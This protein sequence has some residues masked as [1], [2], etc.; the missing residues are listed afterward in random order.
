[1][2]GLHMGHTSVRSNEG[3][4]P[5]S[6]ANR[7]IAEMLK[8]AG[9]VTGGFGKWGLGDADT[10]GVPWR[11]GF[12]RFFGYLHQV[13]AHFYYP[14]ELWDTGTRL[15]LPENAG[16]KKGGYAHDE[17]V[18]RALSFIR[19]NKD[20]PFFCYMPVT[21]PHAELA[22]PEESLALYRGKFPEQPYRNP[23]PGYA[24]PSEPKAT[25]AAMITHMDRSV[26][27]VMRLLEE[28]QI[29]KDT[30]VFFT[31]D[32]GGA[33]PEGTSE[34]FFHANGPLRDYKRS[35]YEGGLR[36]P[37]IARWP[38]Q[39]QAGSESDLACYFPDIMPTLAEL[40]GVKAPTGID[41]LSVVPTLIG[42]K[43]AGRRQKRH[44][45]MYWEYGGTGRLQQA[46][47]TGHW[48]AL[49]LE[50]GRALELYDL[51]TDV[52]ETR[53]VAGEHS[54]VIAV[55]ERFLKSCRTDPPPQVEPPKPEG[56]RWR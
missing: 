34:D 55:I 21:L 46:V 23:R 25:L 17:I 53:N 51:L 27:Q 40:G 9:Y 35:L 29:E 4:V 39:I 7:T 36:V 26:G 11:R 37:M 1:M 43:A 3:G 50:G 10:E 8:Q 28:L 52:G 32:N 47:R 33:D 45:F 15:R 44:D 16:G 18:A 38:G 48:K 24:A 13:H 14:E 20:R 22:V 30:V 2:T 6:P 12:D 49:R 54:Q 31:S 5:L 56:K 42:E 41:G 19:D